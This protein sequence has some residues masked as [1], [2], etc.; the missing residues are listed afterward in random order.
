MESLLHTIYPSDG[1]SAPSSLLALG[2]E[3]EKIKRNFNLQVAIFHKVVRLTWDLLFVYL[4][5]QFYVFLFRK[6]QA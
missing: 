5:L 2:K 4:S 3:E 6:V 1:I